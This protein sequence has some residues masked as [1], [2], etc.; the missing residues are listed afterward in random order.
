MSD[1]IKGEQFQVG[2]VW[3]S[4]K[5]YF[6]KVMENNGSQVVMRMNIHGTGRKIFRNKYKTI[7]WTLEK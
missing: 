2:E 6:Y 5:G 4:P 1:L 3:V 7:G